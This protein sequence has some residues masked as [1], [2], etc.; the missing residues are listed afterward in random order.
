MKLAENTFGETPGAMYLVRELNSISDKALNRSIGRAIT[1]CTTAVNDLVKAV[2]YGH[3]KPKT[4]ANTLRLM[5]E[6]VTNEVSFGLISDLCK[7][8]RIGAIKR[9]ML[10]CTIA[11]KAEHV[12]A[13]P[14]RKGKMVNGHCMP[15]LW[16]EVEFAFTDSITGKEFIAGVVY[17]DFQPDG[18]LVTRVYA[19]IPT[20]EAVNEGAV[21]KLKA[22]SLARCTRQGKPHTL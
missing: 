19:D 13:I 4:A 3:L 22:K 7:N 20:M 2:E 10:L 9:A 11:R 1:S 16:N 18:S 6:E 8:V 5:R 17:Q 12:M 15:D 14:H 21:E